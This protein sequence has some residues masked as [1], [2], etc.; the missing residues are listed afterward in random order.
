MK[1]RNG[2]IIACDTRLNYGSLGKFFNIDD[3][4]QRINENTMIGTS[5]EYSDFQEACRMLKE[6]AFDDVLDSKSFLGPQE[7]TN[8]LSS[9][10]YYKRNK[11]NPFLNST[12]TGGIDWDGKPV[13]FSIDQYGTL[14]KSDY[15]T[16]GMAQYFCNSIIAPEYPINY[17]DLTRDEAVRL[18]EKCFKVLFYRDSRAGNNIKFGYI[19]KRQ[20]GIEYNEFQTVLQTE[21]NFERFRNQAN[22]KIYLTN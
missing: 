22:E 1:Y 14:L 9:V 16:I 12:A 2:I 21:W 17:D 11:M 18:I 20:D 15:V 7:M 6:L 19:E 5:G 10:H 13:L 4:V 8:Y 3:R